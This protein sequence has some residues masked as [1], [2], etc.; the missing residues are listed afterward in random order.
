MKLG[1]RRSGRSRRSTRQ[2]R[3]GRRRTRL[4]SGATRAKAEP[5]EE[6]AKPEGPAADPSRA[7]Q[8]RGRTEAADN[9]GGS[10]TGEGCNREV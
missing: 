3:K 9:T 1:E 5:V 10:E 2:R 8:N 6:E 4:R 7:E